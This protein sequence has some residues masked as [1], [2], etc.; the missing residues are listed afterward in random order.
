MRAALYARVS[1]HDK[2]QDPE[3][4]LA[5]MREYCR[6]MG[7]EIYREYVDYESGSK[8]EREE[9]QEMLNDA[10][11]KKFDILLVWKLDRLARSMKQLIETLDN[12]RA[13]NIE[14]KVITQDID[15][16]TPHGK[17][18]FHIIAAFAEFERELIRE[19][20]R[21]GIAKAKKKGVKVGR[22]PREL[23]RKILERILN[24]REKG[25][26]YGQLS[27]K[28]RIPKTTIYSILKVV[29]KTPSEA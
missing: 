12:L 5:E 8:V 27:K 28:Y 17:L 2:G 11:L 26:S 16:T 29:Q 6:R 7:W 1:T 25:L 9:F 14:F 18:L 22:P 20:V 24:D 3:A 23:D 10:R 4:Q 19:R 21:A 13:W 15:T